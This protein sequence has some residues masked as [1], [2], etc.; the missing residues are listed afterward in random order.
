MFK[1]TK[2]LLFGMVEAIN[3][4]LGFKD[5]DYDTIGSLRIECWKPDNRR[6]YQVHSA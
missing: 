4:E 5:A 2:D 3:E 6:V 1:I